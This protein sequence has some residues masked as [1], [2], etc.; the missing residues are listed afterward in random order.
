MIDFSADTRDIPQLSIDLRDSTTQTCG[1]TYDPLTLK[2]TIFTTK[3]SLKQDDLK[4]QAE[5]LIKSVDSLICSNEE[6]GYLKGGSSSKIKATPFK[7]D[8]ESPV[9]NYFLMGKE[10]TTVTIYNWVFY[11]LV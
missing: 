7:F 1:S 9:T 8:L 5:F 4:A 10:D 11:K 6:N 3:E 2:K